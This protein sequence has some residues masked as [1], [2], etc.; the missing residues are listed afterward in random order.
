MKINHSEHMTGF[1]DKQNNKFTMSMLT[2]DVTHGFYDVPV[3][4]FNHFINNLLP[5]NEFE[6]EFDKH[7][8]KNFSFKTDQFGKVEFKTDFKENVRLV[9]DK[10]GA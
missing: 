1:F 5:N 2:Y 6:I 3:D 10:K 8:E 7:P 9:L 4:K